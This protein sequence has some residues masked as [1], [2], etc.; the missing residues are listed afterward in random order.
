M[1]TIVQE[2]FPVR[3]NVNILNI[4]FNLLLLVDE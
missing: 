2:I 3:L 1:Q 4:C